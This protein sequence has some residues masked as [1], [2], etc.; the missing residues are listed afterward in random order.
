MGEIRGP[1]RGSAALRSG[2]L[3]RHRLHRDYTS[4][5][6]DVY[7]AKDIALTAELR[8]RAAASYA[9]RE[10]VLIGRSA[11]AIYGTK[12]IDPA[13]PAEVARSDHVRAPAGMVV[14]QY[15]IEPDEILR[16]DGLLLTTEART[17]FDIGRTL[18][19][20]EAVMLLDALVYATFVSV[21]D[22]L[23]VADRHPGERGVGQ[24]RRILTDIDGHA[25]SPRETRTRLLLVDAGLPRPESQ[26]TVYDERGHFVARG[27]L[28]WPEWKVLVEYDGEQH[29]TDRRQRARDIDRLTELERAGWRVV[30]V[31]AEH[32]DHRPTELLRRVRDALAAAGFHDHQEVTTVPEPIRRP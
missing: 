27:D 19:R 5:Y 16:R 1:F 21:D 24:L 13:L 4:V 10:A 17:A 14:R 26:V 3:T 30:R 23:E 31:S 28:G 15:R 2:R 7:L 18:P 32:L 11:A 20:T 25:E 8:A 12:W 6:R 29:W 9:G 22:I